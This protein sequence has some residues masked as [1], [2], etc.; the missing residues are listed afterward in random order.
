MRGGGKAK[1]GGKYFICA[2]KGNKKRVTNL[3]QRAN[4]RL[5]PKRDSAVPEIDEQR[6]KINNGVVPHT[7]ECE[8]M[9]EGKRSWTSNGDTR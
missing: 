2:W 4:Q 9:R 6:K 8:Q 3:Q 5:P 1:G 7:Q